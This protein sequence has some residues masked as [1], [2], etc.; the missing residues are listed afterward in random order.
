MRRLFNRRNLDARVFLEI[1]ADGIAWA[2]TGNG[3][4]PRCGC[5]PVPSGNVEETLRSLVDRQGWKGTPATLVLPM[6]QY[7]VFQLDRPDGLEDGELADGVKWRLRDFLDYPPSEAVCD[8]FPLPANASRGQGRQ[9]NVVAAHKA[10]L[11]NPIA[12]IDRCGLRMRAIEV[13]ELAL[14]NL[15][16]ALD[17]G[18]RGVALVH[19]R[20]HYGQLVICRGG[21]LYLSRRLEV[22]SAALRDESLQGQA[23]QGLALEIQRSMDYYESQL[24]QVPPASIQ[25]LAEDAGLSLA[26]RLSANM[27]LAVVAPDWARLG[28]DPV[29]DSHCV[30]PWSAALG[31][32]DTA[33]SLPGE[34]AA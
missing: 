34:Q 13:A 25:L 32:P 20:E 33:A 27:T 21:S 22:S 31:E 2:V 18:G 28:V 9:I 4:W 7:Q 5:C 8:V 16:A 29:P 19:L 15:A 3:A 14:R 30:L 1:G 12:L 26:D 6:D 23:V 11:Q 24:G 10:R 17:D